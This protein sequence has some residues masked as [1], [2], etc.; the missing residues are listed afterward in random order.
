MAFCKYCGTQYPDEGNCPQ[1]NPQ[2]EAVEIPAEPVLAEAQAEAPSGESKAFCK[3]CG[4]EL[5][6]DGQ[7]PCRDQGGA[8]NAF[9]RFCGTSYPA[10]GAC[11]N[12]CQRP[13]AAP[14]AAAPEAFP[15]LRTKRSTLL[16]ILLSALTLG[17]YPIVV[18]HGL[19]KDI[20]TIASPYDDD[21]TPSFIV[22]LLLSMVTFG[23][24]ALVW[25]HKLSKRIGNELQRRNINYKFG[26]KDFWL[27]NTVGCLLLGL[28]PIIYTYNLF[29][30]MQRLAENFNE[31]ELG[32]VPVRPAAPVQ[33]RV[34]ATVG[35]PAAPG[36]VQA[37]P[38]YAAQP[39]APVAVAAQP[40]V[41]KTDAQENLA[42]GILAYL[43][44]LFIVPLFGT[45]KSKF[46]RFHTSQG[47]NLFLGEAGIVVVS[48]ILSIFKSTLVHLVRTAGSTNIY[49]FTSGISPIFTIINVVLWLGA[50]A[51]AVIGIINA[52]QGKEAELPVIGKAKL[53]H[54][55]EEGEPD[56][57]ATGTTLWQYVKKVPKIVYIILAAIVGVL[58]LTSIT[59]SIVDSAKLS[60]A[61]RQAAAIAAQAEEEARRLREEEEEAMRNYTEPPTTTAPAAPEKTLDATTPT[62]A[63]TPAELTL[64]GSAAIS[65]GYVGMVG[66][67]DNGFAFSYTSAQQGTA[68]L[69]AAVR[70][71]EGRPYSIY[72]NDVFFREIEVP[73]AESFSIVPDVPVNF[74]KNTIKIVGT[75]AKYW[76]PDFATLTLTLNSDGDYIDLTEFKIRVPADDSLAPYSVSWETDKYQVAYEYEG[77]QL[78]LGNVI[79]RPATESVEPEGNEVLVFTNDNTNYI[80]VGPQDTVF[81]DG[82][83]SDI[84]LDEFGEIQDI[85][86]AACKKAEVLVEAATTAA[87]TTTAA[88]ATTTAAVSYEGTYV[89]VLTSNEYGANVRMTSTIVLMNGKATFK[90]SGTSSVAGQTVN[91]PESSTDLGAYSVKDGKLLL[92]GVEMGSFDGNKL[93]YMGQV[94]TK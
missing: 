43:G 3:H 71:F 7:C 51:F 76:A 66:G 36:A 1:C 84:A 85:F 67:L 23:I 87:T 38:A 65:E 64:L 82:S 48:I 19:A 4:A 56:F 79:K 29:T 41:P 46:A 47:F 80:F 24:Y 88:A 69:Q 33:Q 63:F 73:G 28:G 49:R 70:P 39:G 21:K 45:K 5:P 34:P 54:V 52:V 94:Y 89:A 44:I 27:W 68:K 90:Q 10:G 11:P 14:M 50:A 57:K 17:I 18:M 15:P 12:G 9:C 35:A 2:A 16:F 42:M 13:Q 74:G 55:S 78:L 22:M 60:S 72:V 30:A 81:L 61:R 8:G 26:A 93:T 75:E 32:I 31:V 59:L 53:L 6:A 20:N 91:I 92:H 40:A 37:Q 25:Y 86:I 58:I 83:S 62:L 77:K